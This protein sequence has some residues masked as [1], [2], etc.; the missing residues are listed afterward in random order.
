MQDKPDNLTTKQKLLVE[1]LPTCDYSI[2]QSA[3]QAGYRPSYAEKLERRIRVKAGINPQLQALQAAIET[4]IRE[5]VPQPD[6]ADERE[7]LRKLV[8]EKLEYIALHGECESNRL[9][10][11]ELLGK[12]QGVFL[13]RSEVSH[14]FAGY[15]P[16]E[17][18]AD[19]ARERMAKAIQSTILADPGIPGGGG[20]T[21]GRL[22]C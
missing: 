14:S 4:R 16:D 3:I 20:V 17:G 13:D 12:T 22:N 19:R 18:N 11:A 6:D 15:N 2:Q 9:K 10:A 8:M 1:N 7:R 5:T 21:G